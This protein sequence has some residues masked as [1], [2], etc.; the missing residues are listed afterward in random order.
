MRVQLW[1]GRS[2]L[3]VDI[4]GIDGEKW[5]ENMEVKHGEVLYHSN[6][7]SLSLSSN[8]AIGPS[9]DTCT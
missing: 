8:L 9:S 5:S 1:L 3:W 6:S 7:R 4:R 2:R